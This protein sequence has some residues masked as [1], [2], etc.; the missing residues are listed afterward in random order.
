[1]SLIGGDA[2]VCRGCHSHATSKVVDLGAQAASDHFPHQTDPLPDAVWPLELWLCSRCALVQLGP[3]VPLVPEPVR[4]VESATSKEHARHAV[5]SVLRDYPSLRGTVVCEFASHHGGSWLDELTAAGCRV[6]D[7]TERAG[8]VV[9]VHG[10]AHETDVRGALE[11]RVARL[12]DGGLLVLEFHHLLPL[13]TGNQ[14]DTIRHGHWS[15]LSL[16]AVQRL[17]DDLG[18]QVVAATGEPVFGG[19]LRV[20]LTQVGADWAREESVDEVLAREAAAGVADEAALR[21]FDGVA[22]RSARAVLGY[23]TEQRAVGRRVLGYGAP[24]K[25][26]VLLGVSQVGTDLLEFTVDASAA[27]HGLAVPG[28]R[29]PIRPVADLQAARPDVVFLLTW[30]IA[31]EVIQALESAGGWGAEY[32]VPLPEPRRVTG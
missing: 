29:I 6:A 31:D 27:K 3:V 4:A 22:K 17:A 9:D 25:A 20:L 23:L 19:S 5:Q 24:S 2:L 21:A 15:Y 16:T 12:A 26:S 30:D 14:Y 8:L 7:D 11:Q 13:V 32:V 1:M 18:L 10:L 28:V